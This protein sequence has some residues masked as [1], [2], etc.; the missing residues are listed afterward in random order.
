MEERTYITQC[1]TIYYWI[2]KIDAV[3]K[4]DDPDALDKSYASKCTL[5]FLPGLTA[6]H[7]LFE[8][9]IEYFE[10]KVNVFVWDAPGHA[11]SWPFD[12]SFDLMGKARWLDEI[13][14]AEDIE[15]PVIVGQSITGYD[16]SGVKNMTFLAFCRVVWLIYLASYRG[17]EANHGSKE[18]GFIFER[19]S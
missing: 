7:S 16:M 3:G 2:S 11:A 12:L 6:D 5:V 4:S 8:K 10:G 13:L 14:T 17:K 15:N 19:T 1:G 9:Q 18:N